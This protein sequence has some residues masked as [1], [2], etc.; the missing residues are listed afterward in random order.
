MNLLAII[1][2]FRFQDVLDVLFL[3]VVAYY[4]FIWFRGTKALKAL[5]GLLGLGIIFTVA[6]T[7]GLF[8]T[9]WVFQ[10]LWQVLETDSA[11]PIRL[12]AMKRLIASLGNSAA[13]RL[14]ALVCRDGFRHQE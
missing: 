1:T 8:L 12:I 13:P 5:V 14:M 2:N 11:A 7:W 10:I 6:R 9:T 4:L 3:T